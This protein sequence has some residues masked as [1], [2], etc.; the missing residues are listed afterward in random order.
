VPICSQFSWFVTSLSITATFSLMHARS[1]YRW[2]A[3][4]KY[5]CFTR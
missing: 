4:F 2:R 1:N 5:S 3:N